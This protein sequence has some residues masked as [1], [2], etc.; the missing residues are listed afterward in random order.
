MNTKK[1]MLIAVIFLAAAII[2]VSSTPMTNHAFAKK[3][4]AQDNSAAQDNSGSKNYENFL[5][6]LSDASGG[7]NS[8]T[9]NQIVNC[10]ADSGYILGSSAAGNTADSQDKTGS[11]DVSTLR[12]QSSSN[13]KSAD[14]SSDEVSAESSSNDSFIDNAID[15]NGNE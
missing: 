12:D 13:D 2:F 4:D 10:F 14:S 3:H 15:D 1:Q 5:N 6:C 8:P 9:G 11:I 7:N